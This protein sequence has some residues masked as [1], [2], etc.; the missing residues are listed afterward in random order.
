MDPLLQGVKAKEQ[1][2]PVCSTRDQRHLA[3]NQDCRT[4]GCERGHMPTQVA[5]RLLEAKNRSA[6]NTV[7]VVPEEPESILSAVQAARL[8][9]GS[10]RLRGGQAS[11]NSNC[12]KNRRKHFSSPPTQHL[13]CNVVVNVPQQYEWLASLATAKLERRRLILE[14]A[15]PPLRGNVANSLEIHEVFLLKSSASRQEKPSACNRNC[16]P[17][18]EHFCHDVA[19]DRCTDMNTAWAKHLNSLLDDNGL[20]TDCESVTHKICDSAA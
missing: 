6:A 2:P 3:G 4:A 10:S 15:H 7:R 16:A 17:P 9:S 20:T 5:T 19:L 11:L 13:A 8:R 1:S 18:D 14:L 12:Q